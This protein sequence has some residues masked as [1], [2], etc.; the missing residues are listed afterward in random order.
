MKASMTATFE[1][2][3]KRVVDLFSDKFEEAK[4]A[5]VAAIE[6]VQA[7]AEAAV[8]DAVSDASFDE[9][10]EVEFD[11]FTGSVQATVRADNVVHFQAGKL[12]AYRK[13][14]VTDA[15]LAAKV[16]KQIIAGES[17][18]SFY[19]SKTQYATLALSGKTAYLADGTSVV[20]P[21]SLG[22]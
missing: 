14:D 18:T 5:A 20:L 11:A 22:V 13:G 12:G 10:D 15:T 3:T 8:E 21:G 1:A 4:E 16:R 7:T 9:E 2:I 6:E 19:G 17:N